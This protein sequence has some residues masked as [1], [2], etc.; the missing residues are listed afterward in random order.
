MLIGQISQSIALLPR[1]TDEGTELWAVSAGSPG[2]A[3]KPCTLSP[4]KCQAWRK[5][6]P[7]QLPLA[8]ATRPR[9]HFLGKDFLLCPSCRPQ[10]QSRTGERRG[11]RGHV[12]QRLARCPTTGQEV[13]GASTEPGPF[14]KPRCKP[15]AALLFVFRLLVADQTPTVRTPGC[16]WS[17][18]LARGGGNPHSLGFRDTREG[19]AAR[20]PKPGQTRGNPRAH[21]LL[22]RTLI[23]FT[24]SPLSTFSPH[25]DGTLVSALRQLA[26]Y[27]GGWERRRQEGRPWVEGAGSRRG[28]RRP[29]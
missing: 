28:P 11:P 6:S 10:G 4:P 13:P 2:P 3:V 1:V 24:H 18:R 14:Q 23:T 22:S 26:G 5:R 29:F 7:T 12:G 15:R 20:G 25:A 16:V 8:F 21:G 27:R 19:R 9:L 17:L